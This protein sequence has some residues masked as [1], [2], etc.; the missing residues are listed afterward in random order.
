M[1]ERRARRTFVA[2]YLAAAGLVAIALWGQL[3]LDLVGLAGADPGP[4]A[5]QALG[6]VSLGLGTASVVYFYLRWSD[7]D[8]GFL[9]VRWPDRRD[10]GHVVVGFAG[11]V[12]LLWAL[13]VAFG[14]LGVSTAQ[15]GTVLD[16]REGDPRI[17]L[18]LVPAAFLLVG[19]GE[20]LLYRNVV[21]KSLYGAFSR[22]GAVVVA[23][24]LFAL[25]HLPAYAAGASSASSLAATLS[26]VFA[27]S[28]VL[29]VVYERTRNTVVPAAV[30][31]A[32]NAVTFLALYASLT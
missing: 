8:A 9:D 20:E 31:G 16:A 15:H 7:R 25:A 32:Y 22:R 23:S 27:L 1:V 11:L 12:A 14:A 21:Q 3:L 24:V 29:G 6:A 13:D 26:V 5:R 19:P 17:L 2:A 18:V 30:H 4:V 28:V 10:V